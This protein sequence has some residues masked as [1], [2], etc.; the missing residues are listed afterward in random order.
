MPPAR[1]YGLTTERWSGKTWAV[2]LHNKMEPRL[3]VPG[4]APFRTIE[5]TGLPL[6]Y[7]QGMLSRREWPRNAR[8]WRSA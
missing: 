2:V 4:G 1:S 8:Y 3:D 7:T 5:L 6:R